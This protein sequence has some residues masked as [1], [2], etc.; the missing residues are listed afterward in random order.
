MGLYRMFGESERSREVN[1]GGGS[2]GKGPAE[3]A[4]R[5]WRIE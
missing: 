4:K 2:Q 5:V 3:R 1:D